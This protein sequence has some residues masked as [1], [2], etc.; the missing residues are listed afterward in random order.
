MSIC[1]N[2]VLK[3]ALVLLQSRS[4]STMPN[5]FCT[6]HI[7]PIAIIDGKRL[8]CLVDTDN[9][10]KFKMSNLPLK[11]AF[12]CNMLNVQAKPRSDLKLTKLLLADVD[13]ATKRNTKSA[14]KVVKSSRKELTFN[15][16]VQVFHRFFCC[17]GEPPVPYF[18]SFFQSLG[19][20][21]IAALLC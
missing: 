14:L 9:C 19:I 17:C 15:L 11:F 16:W 7:I 12:S 20:T 18:H 2:G 5:K 10:R 1:E 13:R 4:C 3:D 8:W 6:S 21:Q